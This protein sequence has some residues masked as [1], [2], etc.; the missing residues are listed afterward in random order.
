MRRYRKTQHSWNETAMKTEDL[1]LFQNSV[2]F[3]TASSD[4]GNFKR[5]RQQKTV[6]SRFYQSIEAAS[7]PLL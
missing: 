3:G 2:S 6:Q 7:L 1:S 4:K 5:G